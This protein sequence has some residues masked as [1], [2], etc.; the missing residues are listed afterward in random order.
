MISLKELLE[1][2]ANSLYGHKKVASVE[3]G[4]VLQKTLRKLFDEAPSDIEIIRFKNGELTL[5]VKSA[6]LLHEITM[7]RNTIIENLNNELGEVLV[8]KIKI[9]P[10]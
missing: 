2:K 5:G 1:S 4:L 3:I 7:N 8:L 10:N 9:K 6:P